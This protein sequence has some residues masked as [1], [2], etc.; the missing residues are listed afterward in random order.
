MKRIIAAILTAVILA[1]LTACEPEKPANA[2]EVG[3]IHTL[4]FK[5]KDKSEEAVATFFNSD[6]EES[7]DV[8]MT[9]CNKSA[10][11]YT[12]SCEGDTSVYNMAYIAYGE[13]RTKIFSFNKCVS[14]WYNCDLGFLPYTQ[15]KKID[16]YPEYEHITLPF[17][18]YEKR[19]HIWTPDNYN[20]ASD[21][22]YATVY[23][24]DGQD[25]AYIGEQWQTPADSDNIPEQITSMTAN[26]GYKAIVV[27]IDTFGDR[28]NY[29][30]DDE[31]VPDLGETVETESYSKKKGTE[32]AAFVAETVV[33]YIRE[34]YNVYTDPLHTSVTGESLGGLEAFYTAMEYPEVFGTA[35]ALSPSFWTYENEIWNTYLSTKEFSD[36]SPFLYLYTGPSG[37]DTD[38]EVTEMYHRLQDMGYPKEK[39]VLHFNPEGCHIITFWRAIFSEFLEAMVYQSVEPLQRPQNTAR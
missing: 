33:P 36:S 35:G 32:L 11:S 1:T 38:P 37:G 21:E 23:V 5:D 30:R 22:K 17:S 27:A 39:L 12:F 9:L 16:Y 2:D 8:P 25:I 19:I 31:L 29:N 6:T 4:Y 26:T 7:V 28:S 15:G 24:Y 34:H 10:D 14:G 18:G 3:S 20:A 13:K